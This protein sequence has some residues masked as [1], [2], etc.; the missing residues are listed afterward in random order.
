MAR[1]VALLDSMWSWAGYNTPGELAPRFFR[2]NPD[3]FSG[4][5]L[6]KLVGNHDLL[7]TNCCSIVQQSANHHGK[8]NVEWVHANLL[9]AQKFDLLLVCG[10]VAKATFEEITSIPSG[11]TDGI[12]Y[13][14][15][16]NLNLIRWYAIDHP[17]ARRWTQEKI[18]QTRLHIERLLCRD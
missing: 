14:E 17:A 2:I 12:A 3:N 4:R 8:P 16:L 10:K 1:V 5:R 11:A 9:R 6:Y 15:G 13:I 7:V 18:E